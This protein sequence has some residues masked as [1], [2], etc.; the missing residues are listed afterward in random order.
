[1]RNGLGAS[2]LPLLHSSTLPPVDGPRMGA[3]P[4][5]LQAVNP[6]AAEVEEGGAER[7]EEPLAAAGGRESAAGSMEVERQLAAG[8][9]R[10][11]GG[12]D[13]P[14]RRQLAPLRERQAHAGLGGDRADG[15]QPRGRREERREAVQVLRIALRHREDA[16]ADRA[17]PGEVQ[18]G[19]ETGRVFL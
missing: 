5:D 4:G 9:G 1:W 17:R 15:D 2:A 7:A 18:G 12:R 11:E 8:P 19:K 14:L 3:R 10:V 6:I 16:D 13:G